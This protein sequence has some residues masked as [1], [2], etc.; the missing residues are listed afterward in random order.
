VSA[1]IQIDSR[2]PA[3][4]AEIVN[5]IHQDDQ[6]MIW[7][8][9]DEESE[10]IAKLIP[11][12]VVLS[13][14]T[15][16]ELRLII[17]ENLRVGNLRVLISKPSIVGTGLNLQFLS[18][19]VFSYSTDSFEQFYQAV[20]RL[21]RYGQKKQVKIYIPYTELEK[22]MLDNVMRKQKTYLEDSEYQEKLYIESLLDELREF[23]SKTMQVSS[24]DETFLPDA[25]GD[26]WRLIHGDC[27]PVMATMP[28]DHFDLAVFSPPFADLYSYTDKTED[29]GNSNSQDDE[30]SLHFSFFAHNLFRVMKPGCIVAMHIAPLA[31]LKSVKG[32]TGIRNF[33][34]ECS[35]IFEKAGFIYQG[36][37]TIGKNPQALRNGTRVLTPHGWRPIESLLVGESVVGSN[38]KPTEVTGVFPHQERAIFRVSFSDGASIDCDRHHLWKVQSYG[39]RSARW[40]TKTTAE[41]FERGVHRPNGDP[42]YRIPTLTH[43]AEFY[44]E[45][46]DEWMQSFSCPKLD[47][48][49]MGVI[50]GDGGISQDRVVEI[51]T[52][53][54]VIQNCVLPAGHGFV[55]RKNSEKANGSVAT[56][57]IT[58]SR[59]HE[60]DVL[61]WLREYGLQGKNA[62]DKFIPE[63]YL[64]AEKYEREELLRGLLDTDGSVHSK[65][66]V[67]YNT[68]SE[69]LAKDIKFLVETLGGLVHIH[70]SDGSKY[71]HNGETR[72]GR[73]IYD[74]TIRLD[75]I[76]CPFKL[77]RKAKKWRPKSKKGFIRS[78]VSIESTG[79]IDNCTCI[80]VAAHDSL[81]VADHC[82]V[83]HNSQ[84]I[85]TKAHA[86]LFKTLKKDS[87]A[88]RFAIPD[89]LMKFSKPG[90]AP[91]IA[92]K[93][94]SN[95]EWIKLAH[96]IWD[97]VDESNTLNRQTKNLSEGDTKHI[98]PLQLEVSDAC[99]RLWSNPGEHV[100]VPFGGI[101]SEGVT[102][103]RN[104]RKV[105]LIELKREYFELAT[106][107]L[108]LE[109]RTK[110]QQ[111]NLFTQRTAT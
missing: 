13:G 51:T 41:L 76:G 21:Q 87:R 59:W 50:L 68:T 106:R 19:C 39:Q 47:P 53:H 35:Q 12:A 14:K 69:Q 37:A 86:L 83:T 55:P 54:E 45:D 30:F 74:L 107:N 18:V 44:K 77:T 48:Y 46:N 109:E 73:T 67:K 91:P 43:S 26:S 28:E 58:C 40:Q 56:Y 72:Q 31:I 80:T 36:Q 90:E 95:E 110:G 82:V 79:E 11:D 100:L 20:G 103:I 1:A 60:N 93:E 4:I 96:P 66:R 33:P 17:L 105:T 108:A 101:G 62:W 8:Q 81:Y 29:L 89:Y 24:N 10:I 78:I 98:A 102:S 97:W 9:F 65:G 42:R 32:Y 5:G 3:R 2:K 71:I 52:D 92:N 88:S 61:D 27:I 15:K 34:Y 64:F 111:L 99:I 63:D 57:A 7:T 6:V 49:T 94:V 16:K 22:P 84:A 38:G 23:T 75:S 25:F 85:R 104:D 70:S